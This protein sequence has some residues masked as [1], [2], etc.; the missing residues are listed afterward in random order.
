M[1]LQMQQLKKRIMRRIYLLFALRNL[2]PLA[3]DCL[4]FIGL[5]FL[6]TIF[7]S[8]RSVISNFSAIRDV[9]GLT[10]YS[11]TALVK[12]KLETKFILLAL[13]VIG[14]LS[15]RD[16]KRAWR[17]VLVLRGKVEKPPVIREMSASP[18]G[19]EETRG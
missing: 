13:G 2:S 8:V 19:S 6:V 1:T 7:V 12:T 18:A 11:L 5:V 3:F 9:G 17:A 15:V 4:A 14:F 10:N 16:L